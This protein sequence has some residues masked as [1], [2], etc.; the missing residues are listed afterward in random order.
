[1]KASRQPSRTCSALP[2][3]AARCTLPATSWPM[4]ARADATSS[5]RSSPRPQ[6]RTEFIVSAPPPLRAV[7]GRRRRPRG[8]GAVAEDRRPTAPGTPKQAKMM[9]ILEEEMQAYVSVLSQHRTKPHSTNPLER[10]NVGIK[11]LRIAPSSQ[12]TSLLISAATGYTLY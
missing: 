3:S 10:L 2:G 6:P 5:R 7:E 4:P 1:M 9:D 12:I 11:R 8:Q